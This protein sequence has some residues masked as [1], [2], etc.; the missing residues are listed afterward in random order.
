M[1]VDS[2]STEQALLHFV[3]QR[4]LT[5]TAEAVAEGFAAAQLSRLV[6]KGA[7]VRLSRGLYE[8]HEPGHVSEHHSLAEAARA[9]PG[10]V[11]CL[12]SALAF[13]GI[14]T[15]MPHRVWLA[16]ERKREK[17][18]ATHPPL[19]LVWLSPHLL[20]SGVETHAIDGVPVAITNPART[21]VDCFKFRHRVGLD[22]ALEALRES[23][24]E[25]RLN[26]DELACEAKTC[27]VWTV[28]RPYLEALSI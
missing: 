20:K 3:Q 5:R 24:R 19:R 11:I 28:L 22:V 8:A 2:N 27:R 13:H 14:G 17:P 1:P 9:V 23:L 6:A 21:V 26:R 18:R 7:L 15:Q 25:R 10:G 16:I 12:L 4:G